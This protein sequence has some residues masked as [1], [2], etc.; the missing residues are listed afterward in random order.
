MVS[1]RPVSPLLQEGTTICRGNRSS[2]VKQQGDRVPPLAVPA[3]NT[4]SQLPGTEHVRGVE[5]KVGPDTRG[6]S[7]GR[8]GDQTSSARFRYHFASLRVPGQVVRSEG[9]SFPPLD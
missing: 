6:G 7:A 3:R 2:T 4:N 1:A 8:N 9:C 5:D